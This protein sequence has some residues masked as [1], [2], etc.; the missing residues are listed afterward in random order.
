MAILVAPVVSQLS[1]LPV[2]EF[3]LAGAAVKEVIAGAESGAE[4]EFDCIAEV[5]PASPTLANRISA[6][7]QGSSPEAR[8]H[9]VLSP[10]LQN[11][12]AESMRSP[13]VVVDGIILATP[14]SPQSVFQMPHRSQ[15]M[16]LVM[17]KMAG[18]QTALSFF[19]KERC[20]GPEKRTQ[21]SGASSDP[22]PAG[23]R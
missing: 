22:S 19:D 8:S 16:T 6:I 15:G 17:A 2:P 4:D 21:T 18:R 13:L 20:I 12:P 9:R 1:V 7:A 5:Q 14:S 3:M 10:I 11:E 23:G